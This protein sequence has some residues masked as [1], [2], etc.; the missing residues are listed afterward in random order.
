MPPCFGLHIL[1]SVSVAHP[2]YCC[3][4]VKT[5]LLTPTTTSGSWCDP[6]E[7]QLVRQSCLTEH[8]SQESRVPGLCSAT[9]AD[10]HLQRFTSCSR[11]GHHKPPCPHA[12][13]TPISCLPCTGERAKSIPGKF[14]GFKIWLWLETRK[15]LVKWR[16][17]RWK[18]FD[19]VKC[20]LG[21]F[22]PFLL[23]FIWQMGWTLKDQQYHNLKLTNPSLLCMWESAACPAIPP[24]TSSQVMETP[25][26][27]IPNSWW[28]HSRHVW[29]HDGKKAC[30]QLSD[31]QGWA[32]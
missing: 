25:T 23:T 3:T 22:N 15:I 19:K 7:A 13:K 6:G 1:F 30:F 29:L 31:T 27:P 24:Q 12:G 4:T 16:S 20:I 18:C 5:C 17:R 28:L 10:R 26:W 8:L 9:P 14:S 21:N 32:A 11:G 2:F